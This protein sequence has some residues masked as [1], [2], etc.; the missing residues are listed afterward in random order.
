MERI[1]EKYQIPCEWVIDGYMHCNHKVN[2]IISD[3]LM[4]MI[5]P[6]LAN[7]PAKYLVS[8]IGNDVKDYVYEKYIEKN[9]YLCNL[10]VGS[11][12]GSIVMNCNPFTKGHRFLIEESSKYVDWLIVFVVEED[13]S[14]FTFEER[15][16]LVKEGTKDLAN[17]IVVP[18]GEFILSG[19]NFSEYFSKKENEVAVLNAEYDINIFA[20]YI[21][22][23]FHIS[24]RFAGEE[25]IDRLT[26]I[27][28]KTMRE[29]LP[30]KGIEFIE[31]PRIIID[32]EVV[33]ASVVRKYLQERE[34]KKAFALVPETTKRY[35]EQ[36]CYDY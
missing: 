18:G 5:E 4:K 13:V 32:K 22:K 12:I 9:I 26:S 7:K 20:D 35:L 28:N 33:S 36:Q 23:A 30:N 16:W 24:C 19:N 27:Y 29:I 14:L 21:A 31:L 10:T 1:F 15:Y 2:K 6:Y 3:S 34:Y 25:P 8:D 17:V 11:K